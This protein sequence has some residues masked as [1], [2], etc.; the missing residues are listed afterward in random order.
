[1]NSDEEWHDVQKMLELAEEMQEKID[2]SSRLST[3]GESLFTLLAAASLGGAAFLTSHPK[4]LALIDPAYYVAW[5]LALTGSLFQWLQ[6][7]SMNQRVFRREG[8][9]MV[10]VLDL[11]HEVDASLSLSKLQKA[12][13][14][15]RLARLDMTASSGGGLISRAI[16]VLLASPAGSGPTKDRDPYDRM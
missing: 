13:L 8:R 15:I 16:R 5:T 10:R 14:R 3:A 2:R 1:M 11:L 6:R 9:A 4:T 12:E 7:R